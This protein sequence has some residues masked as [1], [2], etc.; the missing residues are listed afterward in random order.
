MS[1][2]NSPD[3][4]STAI[5]YDWSGSR[6]STPLE[7]TIPEAIAEATGRDP[8][9]S[10][11][12]QQYADVDALETLLA[13]SDDVSISFTYAGVSVTLYGDGAVHVEE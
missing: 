3:G 1:S 2:S 12:L 6:G 8:T 11:P 10:P 9:E 13:G 4:S 7:V 5:D